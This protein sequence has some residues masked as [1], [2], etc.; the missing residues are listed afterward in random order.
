MMIL[1]RMEKFSLVQF[2]KHLSILSYV[3]GSIS[4]R[5]YAYMSSPCFKDR[6]C[7]KYK[8]INCSNIYWDPRRGI[9]YLT[10]R[11]MGTFSGR[12]ST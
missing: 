9:I 10:Q 5:R 3:F 12:N 1:N 11:E 2:N 6:N 8:M 7:Q 4:D